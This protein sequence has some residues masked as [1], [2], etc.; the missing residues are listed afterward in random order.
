MWHQIMQ[1]RDSQEDFENI[2]TVPRTNKQLIQSVK[3]SDAF[4]GGSG[5]WRGGV[6]QGGKERIK[7]GAEVPSV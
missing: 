3:R 7:A 2:S 1:R 5:N 6:T 4:W